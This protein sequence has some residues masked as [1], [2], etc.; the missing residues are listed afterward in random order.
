MKSVKQLAGQSQASA[1]SIRPVILASFIGTA[2][3]WYD[4]FLYGTA[5]ALVFNKLFFPNV[6]PLAGTLSAFGTFAVGFVARPVGGVIFGHF[7]DRIGRKSMLIY[8]LLIMGTATFIIG[9][10]PTY[11]SIGIWAPLLLVTMRFAQ[12]IGVG[13]EWGG[14]VLMAV[15]HSTK[16]SRGFHGSW[17]Q[18]GVGA[19][20]LLSTITFTLFSSSLSQ[21]EFLAWGWRIPFLLSVI[22]IGVGLFIRLRIFETPI[23]ARLKQARGETQRP[24]VEVLRQQPKDILLAMG[25]RFAENGPFYIMSVFVLSYGE[26]HLRLPRS[27]MLTGVII[28][29]AISLLVIPVYGALSD[30]IGRRPVYQ[31][32]AL[33]TL[34]FAFPFFWL[35]ETR[36]PGLIWLAIALA[37]NVGHDPMYAVQAS[38]FSELFGTRVRYTGAS[39][40]YQ[41]SSVF[42]GGLAP[43]IATGLLAWLGSPAV[44]GYVAAMALI[45]IVSTYLATETFRDEI[46]Q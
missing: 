38:Y 9:L 34:L 39:L 5:A 16:G 11:A 25:M 32:G 14:A 8:S 12:G 21:A 13:G 7:G 20:L 3:E 37:V 40:S 1:T 31:A 28:A 2:I 22:L 27:T 10:L 26:A 24:I 43:L 41:L 45:T 36:S 30:Q 42:A 4:F 15:E 29:S 35:L 46:S 6:S 23:F 33:F 18:M 44:A 19:G 17:V